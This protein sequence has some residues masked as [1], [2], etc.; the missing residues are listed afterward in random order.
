MSLTKSKEA[1][2]AAI[3][4]LRTVESDLI[5]ERRSEYMTALELLAKYNGELRREKA[6]FQSLAETATR[7]GE[8]VREQQLSKQV[9]Q[10]EAE[11]VRLKE[12]V[13]RERN[14]P[15][16]PTYDEVVHALAALVK[17]TDS[18]KEI[19]S[20]LTNIA[21]LS[22]ECVAKVL[23]TEHTGEVVVLPDEQW[24]AATRHVFDAVRAIVGEISPE[25]G[26][27]LEIVTQPEKM[28]KGRSAIHAGRVA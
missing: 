12:A 4:T 10:L 21:W 25:T 19:V 5:G 18:N 28:R 1:A 9:A 22:L 17:A 3:N 15:I 8:T 20:H 27:Q 14:K 16:Q 24:D 26:E 7:P 6:V 2:K 23:V 11:I 13:E